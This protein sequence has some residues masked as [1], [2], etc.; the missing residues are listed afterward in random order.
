MLRKRF[1]SRPIVKNS[2]P[3]VFTIMVVS[4]YGRTRTLSVSRRMI[5]AIGCTLALIAVTCLF[6]SAGFAAAMRKV[7]EL[8]YLEGFRDNVRTE[9]TDLQEELQTIRQELDDAQMEVGR[10][11]D[12]LRSEGIFDTQTSSQGDKWRAAESPISLSRGGSWRA[13]SPQEMLRAVKELQEESEA[14]MT[15]LA[16]LKEDTAQVS[17]EVSAEVA[18]RRA[19]PCTCPVQG[20]ITST[21]GWRSH[22]V[23]G[24]RAFH[25]GADFGAPVGTLIHAT[26]DGVVKAAGRDGGYGLRIIID[27]GYGIETLYGHCSKLEAKVGQKVERGDVIARVGDTGTSTGPHV[28]Y[29]VRLNG[30]PVDP[31][32]YLPD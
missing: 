12:V 10:V 32:S 2:R 19:I 20:R 15:L 11:R 14:L 22:P 5:V 13:S 29:E 8:R 21:F 31:A 3:R 9:I 23:S 18:Y 30:E 1:A 28:H 17:L 27:H 6:S 7:A 24:V 25:N 4:S 26:A 16:R